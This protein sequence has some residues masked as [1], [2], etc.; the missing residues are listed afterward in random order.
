MQSITRF[1]RDLERVNTHQDTAE[2][3]P[4]FQAQGL[5]KTSRAAT[6]GGPKFF[7]CTLFDFIGQPCS[8]GSM[9]PKNLSILVTMANAISKR[10]NGDG[11][12]S[13]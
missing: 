4:S 7:D 2:R 8:F 11:P 13:I 5:R 12:V 3:T 10:A 1:S 9:S 6:P